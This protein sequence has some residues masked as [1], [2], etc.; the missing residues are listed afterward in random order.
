M[1]Y[2]LV[3]NRTLSIYVTG[4]PYEIMTIPHHATT[5]K[6]P[7]VKKLQNS[8]IL[9][10]DFVRKTACFYVGE[11]PFREGRL[12]LSLIQGKNVLFKLQL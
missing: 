7:H 12:L 4:F 5:P 10:I 8:P 11:D 9:N 6:T 3:L 1:F 2:W